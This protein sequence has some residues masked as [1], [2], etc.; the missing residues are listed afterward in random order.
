MLFLQ[1]NFTVPEQLPENVA[2]DEAVLKNIHEVLSEVCTCECCIAK[3]WPKTL[4]PFKA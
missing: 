4:M 1:L 3:S 2:E